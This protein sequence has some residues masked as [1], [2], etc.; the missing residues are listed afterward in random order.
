MSK[1][2]TP[3]KTDA[4]PHQQAAPGRVF[5]FS[6][7]GIPPV[8]PEMWAKM[9]AAARIPRKGRRYPEIVE[10]PDGSI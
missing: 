7:K 10:V 1:A 4:T 5:K 8:T 3:R 6:F 9:E 2:P